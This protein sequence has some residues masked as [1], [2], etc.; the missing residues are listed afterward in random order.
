MIVRTEAVILKAMDFRESSRILTVYTRDF[1]K[2]SLLAKGVRGA[3]SRLAGVTA[4]LN[5]VTLVYYRK[6][7]RDLQLLSQCDLVR[8][9]RRITDSLEAMAAAMGICELLNL[10]VQGE[11]EHPALFDLL[12]GTLDVVNDA[13]NNS[14]NAFYLFE[15][16]VLGLLGFRPELR[17]CGR[18][19]R[20][21]G[22]HEDRKVALDAPH[23]S[24][25]CADCTA[26]GH[27]GDVISPA[28]LAVLRRF[29]EISDIGAVC[30]I[31][32]PEATKREVGSALRRLLQSHVE[33]LRSLKS[34]AVFSSLL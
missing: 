20:T 29:Q 12:V 22:E 9:W 1:G 4:P 31:A 27:G 26:A 30:R 14:L 13:T 25:C 10:V 7:Q 6:E 16:R 2:Q 8:P 11:E 5:Y 18:C 15:I 21:L 24:I 28:A 33:G 32:L 23:G 34:E 3:K 17:I 19:G